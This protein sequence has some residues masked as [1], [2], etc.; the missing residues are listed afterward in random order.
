MAGNKVRLLR[1]GREAFPTMLRAIEQAQE[2]VLLEMYWFDS[3]A[4]GSR[5]A[6]ALIHAAIRGVE[7]CVIYD[8][9]GSIEASSAMFDSMRDAGV[10]VVEFNPIMPWHQ[11][12]RVALLTRRD[13][14]KILVVDQ[15]LGFTG[16]IN[17][18]NHWAP[19]EQ[20]GGGWRDDMV[21]V[22]GAAVAGFVDCFR[23]TW[24]E[25]GGEPVAFVDRAPGTSKDTTGQRVRVLGEAIHRERREIVRAYLYHIYRA[26]KRVWIANSYFVPEGRIV[27]ALSY[28]AL[29]GVD[30]RVLLPGHS[31]VE[32]VRLA[33]RAIY[34]RMLKSGIHI[35][36]WQKNVLHSKTAVI[37][38]RW[39]TVGTFNL[40]YRSLRTNLEVNVA[41]LDAGF[42][43][44]MEESFQADCA[45]SEEI[46]YA[47]FNRRSLPQRFLEQAAYRL[48]TLL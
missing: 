21:E 46:S 26:R 2:Q 28:A 42:G 29:R 3:D 7:V 18:A 14:R 47:D 44:V 1:N 24:E 5:F 38:G 11:R 34:E 23:S 19:S 39:S 22:E 9:L 30:V 13:H 4:T 20:G 48:K 10:K 41:V 12:F 8:S 36:E 25:E 31:D 16:G 33:S 43:S 6:E 37:D 40:D 35:F 32:I 17:I 15:K 27:R 45:E